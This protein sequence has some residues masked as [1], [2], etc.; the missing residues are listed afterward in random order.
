MTQKVDNIKDEAFPVEYDEDQLP[1]EATD[2]LFSYIFHNSEVNQQLS[3][4]HLCCSVNN[5]FPSKLLL[6]SDFA[7]VMPKKKHVNSFIKNVTN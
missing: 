5:L 6:K 3:N 7:R 1:L 2:Q 4:P